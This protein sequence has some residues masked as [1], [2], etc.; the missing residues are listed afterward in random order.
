[1]RVSFNE[2][3]TTLRKA[4]IGAGFPVG[5][6]EDCASAAAWL[7]GQGHDGVESVLEAVRDEMQ[8]QAMPSAIGNAWVFPDAGIAMCGP[9]A[10]D[11][12]MAAACQEVRLLK[13]DS[14][15][16]MI[17]LAGVAAGNYGREFSLENDAGCSV[18]IS[19]GGMSLT[20]ALPSPGANLSLTC[21]EDSRVGMRTPALLQGAIVDDRVWRE[22]LAL[23]ART[24]VPSSTASR[25][26]GAGAGLTD[27]D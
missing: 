4:A 12:L 20:G 1:M 7:V 22:A 13:A 19:A 5:L 17:G 15:L 11:L 8:K 10:I 27:N 23:A 18:Q 26:A 24:Y 16:M 14:P 3:E 25:A 2:I 6:A 21:R 9:S